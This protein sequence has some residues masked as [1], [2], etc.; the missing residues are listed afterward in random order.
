[1]KEGKFRILHVCEHPVQYNTT[2]WQMQARHPKLDILV[3]YRSLQGAVPAVNPGF[4]VEVAWDVPLLDGYPWTIVSSA[5]R[6][7]NGRRRLGLFSKELWGLIKRGGFDAVSLGGYYFPEAWMAIL[8][9][10]T[11]RVPI[12]L[13][14]DAHGLESSRAKS[15]AALAIKKLIV[16]R[17]FRMAAAVVT[18]SSKAEIFLQALGVSRDRIFL[19]RSV[20]DNTWWTDHARQTDR[21]AVR[22]EWNL[23]AGAAVALYCAK[24]QPWKRP[25]DLLEAFSRANVTGSYLVFAGD[26]PL[27]PILERRSKDLGVAD[28]VRFLGFVNQTALPRVYV[29]CDVLVLPSDYEPFGLVVNEAM[30]CRCPV[31]VSD[32]V[33]AR[34]DL[35]REGETGCVFPCGDVEALA[36]ILGALLGNRSRLERMGEAAR[37]RMQTWTP[38]MNVETFVE[39]I[40]MA[41]AGN[42]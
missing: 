10:K 37:D 13:S 27:R 26:G 31:I 35:V 40:E 28:R 20:V 14:T 6:G 1:M 30:L 29:T 19:G 5:E 32:R 42:K 34:H 22:R 11:N 17:I 7:R 23:P 33:G 15:K 2:L 38:E 4:G 39:A 21:L 41:V 12:I 18:S 24:L 3:A 25:G 36:R 8:A 16:G 9:A